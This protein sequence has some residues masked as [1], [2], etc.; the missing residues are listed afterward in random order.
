M[1]R[2]DLKIESTC[3]S[4][5]VIGRGGDGDRARKTCDYN[6]H[7]TRRRSLTTS[8]TRRETR[9]AIFTVAQLN[10]PGISWLTRRVWRW[11]WNAMEEEIFH[12]IR[13]CAD[14]GYHPKAKQRLFKPTIIQINSTS[15]SPRENTRKIPGKKTIIYSS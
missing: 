3:G 1:I 4:G 11:A 14:L 9:D 10:T 7:L 15:R 12:L 5:N 8:V 13:L 6:T 2:N